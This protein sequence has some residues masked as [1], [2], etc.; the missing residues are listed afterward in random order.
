LASP[1]VTFLLP[2]SRAAAAALATP[3]SYDM[4]EGMLKEFERT[5]SPSRNTPLRMPQLGHLPVYMPEKDLVRRIPSRRHF[6]S[7]RGKLFWLLALS[8]AMCNLRG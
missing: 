2:S 1:S 4:S 5:F 7:R 8:P 6:L 3:M